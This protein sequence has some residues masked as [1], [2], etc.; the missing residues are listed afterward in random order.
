MTRFYMIFIFLAFF[1]V[2]TSADSSALSSGPEDE[3]AVKDNAS[4]SKDVE[5]AKDVEPKEDE[6]GEISGNKTVPDPLEP[7]NRLV[8]TFNDRLYFWVVKPAA[9]GYNAVLPEPVRSSVQNFFDNLSMPVRFVSSVLQV[10][11]KS[12]GIELAR[13]G[14]NSVF[15]IGGLFDIA[16]SY[17]LEP[18][19][20]DL[21]LT[22]G[23]YGIGEGLY[24]V[25]PFLGPS[26]LRDTVGS[27]GDGFLS[28]TNYI[29]PARDSLAVNGYAYFNNASLHIGDYEDL[30]ESAIDPYI[31]LKDAYVQ[32]RIYLIKK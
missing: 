23:Y 6:S 9:Q 12:A 3:T 24:I 14:V 31:A 30:K 4:A 1:L 5:P 10:K 29:T 19:E 21:G 26:S 15:G 20:K 13:F 32:H 2:A 8:F 7:W 27:V 16:R 18:Q 11:L 22:F 28:P 17:N 25:W